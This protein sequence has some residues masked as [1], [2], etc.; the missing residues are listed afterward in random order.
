M[1][2]LKIVRTK[3]TTVLRKNQKHM[4]VRINHNTLLI[5]LPFWTL[6]HDLFKSYFIRIVCL[7]LGKNK[8]H[9][10]VQSLQWNGLIITCQ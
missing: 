3:K 1:R 8:V 10:T 2:Y 6:A 5:W 4:D 9:I 7:H